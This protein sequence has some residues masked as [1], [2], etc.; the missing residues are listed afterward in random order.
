MTCDAYYD[1]HPNA[2]P[3]VG[4]PDRCAIPEINANTARSLSLLGS[5]M[6]FFGIMNLFITT[7]AIKRFGVK[8]TLAMQVF[9]P[10]FRLAVQY[11]GIVIGGNT[12]IIIVQSSQVITIIGGPVGYMLAL[13][14]YVVE[15]TQDKERTGYLGILQGYNMLGMVSSIR[16]HMTLSTRTT[17][18]QT[19]RRQDYWQ[20]A[21]SSTPSASSCRSK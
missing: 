10:G 12:G 7:A 1:A 6:T 21:S 15:T 19:T 11:V 4:T 14:T 3:P 8:A 20:E 5:S 9:W 17:L 13:N 2:P 18:T 16:G